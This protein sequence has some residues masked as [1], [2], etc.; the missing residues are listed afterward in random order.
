MPRAGSSSTTTKKT[1]KGRAAA[2]TN[3]ALA[4]ANARMQG[5]SDISN[6]IFSLACSCLTFPS[7]QLADLQAQLAVTR[8]QATVPALTTAVSTEIIPRPA[9]EHGRNWNLCTKLA[10]YGITRNEYKH[11]LVSLHHLIFSY[12]YIILG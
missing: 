6:S 2:D 12:V 4:E 9:G 10:E 7:A 11:M 5:N 1:K 8:A 3:K